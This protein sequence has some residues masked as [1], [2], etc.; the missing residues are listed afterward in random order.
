[1]TYTSFVERVKNGE[2]FRIDFAKRIATLN[3]NRLEVEP[4]VPVCS[5]SEALSLIELHYLTY[6]KSVPNERNDSRRRRYFVADKMNDLSDEELC[7][8]VDREVAQAELEMLVLCLILNG[9]LYW[10][11]T[12]MGGKWFWQS[13]NYP[14]LVILKEW[15]S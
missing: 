15:I 3:G 12:L 1:M 14:D 9:S 8:G 5:I 6:K 2:K 10:D 7:I 4:D 13:K 11:D